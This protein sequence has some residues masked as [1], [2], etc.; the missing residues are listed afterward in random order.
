MCSQDCW[1]N[2]WYT[3]EN[4]QR[5][6]RQ[7]YR[8]GTSTTQYSSQPPVGQ[9][10][11]YEFSH[12]ASNILIGRVRILVCG[13]NISENLAKLEKAPNILSLSK[14]VVYVVRSYTWWHL[15]LCN[16]LSEAIIVTIFEHYQATIW[17]G[18]I[19][20]DINDNAN[21]ISVFGDSHLSPHLSLELLITWT[22]NTD[23]QIRDSQRN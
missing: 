15:H 4:D 10:E 17:Y 5:L 1:T 11:Y 14:V 18:L 21:D 12:S 9:R 3:F 2:T 20:Q 8:L 7:R 16:K 23:T 19:R 13:A 6:L 22:L